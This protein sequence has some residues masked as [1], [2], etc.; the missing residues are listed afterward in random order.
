ME[1]T[2][3]KVLAMKPG[4]ELDALVAERV[5]GIILPNIHN[6]NFYST[7]IDAAW[8]LV[9]KMRDNKIYLDIRVWPDEYQ[10]LPHENE[11][12]KLVYEWIVKRKSLTEAICKAALL[13][14]IKE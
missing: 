10:V 14:T 12:N 5:M 8:E 11:N 6:A 13:T 3:E 2:R 7:D 4:R 1:L 9:E